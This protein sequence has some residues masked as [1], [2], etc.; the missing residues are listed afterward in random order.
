[1]KEQA[2]TSVFLL[3]ISP[4][5]QRDF[6]RVLVLGGDWI[7]LE[8]AERLGR[9]GFE[10][11]LLG[12]EET[13][14]SPKGVTLLPSATLE[15][16]KGFV[17][18]FTAILRTA[19][20]RVQE[21]VGSVVAA[22][23]ARLVPKYDEYGLS[24]R[25][26]ILSLSDL[27]V[28]L[29]R[30][31]VM[32]PGRGPWCHVAFLCGLK[33]ESHPAIFTRVLDAMEKIAAMENT[34]SYVF[35]RNL[36][37]ASPGLEQRY[38]E[39]RDRG[40]LYF[41]FDADGIVTSSQDGRT[42]L[43]FQEPL[44]GAE[45]E[46][47][48]DMVVVD[49]SMLPPDSVAPLLNAIPSSPAFGPFLEPESIRFP[50]VQTPKAGFYAVGPSRGVFSPAMI[51]GDIDAAVEALKRTL[52][53]PDRTGWGAPQVDAARCTMCLT[54]VRLCPHGA[55]GFHEKAEAD[56]V[57]CVRCGICAAEC[58]MAAITLAP[59]AYIKDVERAGGHCTSARGSRKTIVAYVCSRSANDALAAISPA[60]VQDVTVIPVPCAGTVSVLHILT[61]LGNGAAGVLVAGCYKGNCA[62]IYGTVLAGQRS[63]EAQRLLEEAGVQP[64]K[65]VFTSCASNAPG[66]LA[67]A[68]QEL[69]QSVY[70]EE[71]SS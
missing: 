56:P 3:G 49:E 47:E 28:R 68:L 35:T 13:G 34:Q 14:N 36:K 4:P 18:D 22:S 25:D 60:L 15:E 71:E 16:I 24:C 8:L 40:T 57:S 10:V 48:P 20:G 5:E 69:Q 52:P 26:R 63:A 31:D 55:M 66:N 38:L 44:L 45:V 50:G 62:S 53:S 64:G 39:S 1:V 43:V 37:V 29:Q 46:L 30:G 70:A 59:P 12:Q 51:R 2:L 11:L 17:G 58:P 42:T 61:A 33:G 41:K 19:D 6:G 67:A 54:C 65:V 27:E 21:R 7:G 32:E 9:E 23:P